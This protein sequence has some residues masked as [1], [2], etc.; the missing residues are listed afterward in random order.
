MVRFEVALDQDGR[1]PQWSK[2]VLEKHGLYVFRSG[3][4]ILRIGESSSG[5]AR[6]VKGFR[7]PLRKLLRGKER[8]NYLAYAW[9][10]KHA[11]RSLTVDFFNLPEQPF[12]DS[13][14]RRSLEAEVTFQLR[15]AMKYW[16]REMSEIHFLEKS[17]THPDVVAQATRVLQEYGYSYNGDI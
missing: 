6:I 9:R 8:K 7:E 10:L 12:A 17:R 5:C 16:P 2:P 14:L 3:T 1:L 4:D 13:Y 11:G 15:I